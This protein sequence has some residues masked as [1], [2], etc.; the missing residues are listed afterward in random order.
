MDHPAAASAP[1][2]LDLAGGWTDVG[3]YPYDFGGEVVNFAINL[4]VTAELNPP[5]D[6]EVVFPV[7]R[8]SGLGTSSAL[9]SSTEALSN[10]GKSKTI[11]FSREG[12]LL[13]V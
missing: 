12:I 13:R 8:G 5:S 4:R 7:Q 10:P 11:S 2:R 9:S 1:I 3:P 6:I